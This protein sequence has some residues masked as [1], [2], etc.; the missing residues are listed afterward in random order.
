MKLRLRQALVDSHVAAAAITILLVWSVEWVCQALSEP[1]VRL[2]TFLATAV[3]IRGIPYIA[4]TPNFDDRL[5]LLVT[6]IYL[7]Q[8][9]TAVAAA[10]L[11]SR[12]VYGTGPIHSLSSYRGRLTRRSH[13]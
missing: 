1:I 2:G 9:L 13:A 12:W 5:I 4:P 7:I 11:L 10:W 8:A 3:A 6:S